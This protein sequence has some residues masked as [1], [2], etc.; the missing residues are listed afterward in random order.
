M[1]IK[2]M[3]QWGVGVMTERLKSKTGGSKSGYKVL[4][5]MLPT[6]DLIWE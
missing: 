3:G 2:S 1:I 4:V 6:L 5:R